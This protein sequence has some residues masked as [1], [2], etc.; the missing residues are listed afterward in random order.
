M[1]SFAAAA[2]STPTAEGLLPRG[3]AP[4]RCRSRWCSRRRR[5]RRR[6]VVVRSVQILR[7]T[8]RA[9]PPNPR[10]GSLLLRARRVRGLSVLPDAVASK[11][12]VDEPAAGINVHRCGAL[13]WRLAHLLE[14][15]EVLAGRGVGGE[16]REEGVGRSEA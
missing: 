11:S 13:L 14:P 5:R 7:G 15:P 4:G 16:G 9:A 3:G 8:S 6:F 2:A 12:G 10:L 1:L